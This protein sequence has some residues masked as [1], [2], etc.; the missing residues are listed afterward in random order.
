MRP[1]SS[2]TQSSGLSPG[3]RCADLG[4]GTGVHTLWMVELVALGE[5]VAVDSSEGMLEQARRGAE[6]CGCVLSTVRADAE[7]F[8]G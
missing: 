7:S 5:V 1:P 3:L 8:I 4:C 2:L 6:S